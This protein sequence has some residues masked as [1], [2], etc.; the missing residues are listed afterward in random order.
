M[1]KKIGRKI[2]K[3]ERINRKNMLWILSRPLRGKM[4]VK[5]ADTSNKIY[6][7]FLSFGFINTERA[8]A[9]RTKARIPKKTKELFIQVVP[10][11]RL[12]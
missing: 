7:K 8:L 6:T 10:N 2:N 5:D 9:K 12:N 11:S 3:T 1:A 4:K